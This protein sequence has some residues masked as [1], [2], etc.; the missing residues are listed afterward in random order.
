LGIFLIHPGCGGSCAFESNVPN[1][2]RVSIRAII[3]NVFKA[4]MLNNNPKNPNPDV[5][6]EYFPN[7]LT[8]DTIESV[9]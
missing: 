3:L 8:N 5:K 7:L 9:K 1:S 6:G 4:A 2:P